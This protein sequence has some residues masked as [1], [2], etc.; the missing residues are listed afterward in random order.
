MATATQEQ[1]VDLADVARRLDLFARELD[2]Y[3]AKMYSLGEEVDRGNDDAVT[4]L[5]HCGETNNQIFLETMAH[6]DK[7]RKLYND[8]MR[9]CSYIDEDTVTPVFEPT[10]NDDD[11][12]QR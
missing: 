4:R 1:P 3:S 10:H 2:D 9:V 12:N 5:F 8:L 7:A 6:A 11:T